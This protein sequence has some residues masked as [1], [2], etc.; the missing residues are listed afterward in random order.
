MKEQ[1]FYREP[2]MPERV[3]FINQWWPHFGTYWVAEHLGL[4]R[5]QVKSKA[6]GSGL[7]MLPKEAR[8]CVECRQDYQYARH[9]GLRCR[10]CHLNRRKDTRR[11]LAVPASQKARKQ[12]TPK[13]QSDRERWMAMAINTAKMRSTLPCDLSVGYM[14]DLWENQDGRCYYSGLP[15]REPVYGSGR[16]AHVA[17]IDRL[18]PQGGYTQDNVVWATWICNQAKNS[19]SVDEYVNLCAQVSRHRQAQQEFARDIAIDH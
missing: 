2:W 18:N 19:L 1:L 13:Y 16:H 4:S 14:L 17:S 3:A 11:G 9:A 8:L 7:K 5:Q 15:L 12:R 10:S 6:D